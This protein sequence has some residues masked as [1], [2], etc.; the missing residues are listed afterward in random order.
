MDMVIC[1]YNPLR[2][3]TRGKLCDYDSIEDFQKDYIRR[4]YQQ[5]PGGWADIELFLADN[6]PFHGSTLRKYFDDIDKEIRKRVSKA[7]YY[8]GYGQLYI[9][10][11]E[12]PNR[13]MHNLSMLLQAASRVINGIRL[14]MLINFN[15]TYKRIISHLK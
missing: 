13:A 15:S 7:D 1:K 8:E 3:L 5:A 6:T 4:L 11:S 10:W 12:D 9:P 2:L 14:D